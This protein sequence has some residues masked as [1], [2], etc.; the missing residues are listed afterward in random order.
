MPDLTP[1]TAERWVQSYFDSPHT[2][3]LSLGAA[4]AVGMW[5]VGALQVAFSQPPTWVY[6][7]S[8]LAVSGI[9]YGIDVAATS[10]YAWYARDG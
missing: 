8:A 3:H 5:V 6:V 1:E 10:L 9:T 4:A 7:G 2:V